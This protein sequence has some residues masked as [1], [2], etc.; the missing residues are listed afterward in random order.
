FDNMEKRPIKGTS[1]WVKYE[2]VLFVPVEATSISYGVLLAGTGQV[3]FKGVKFEIV[4]DTVPETG[5][6]KGRENKVLSFEVKAKAM[7]NEIKRITDEEKNTLKEEVSSID[8]EI[9]EGIISKEKAAELK[10]KKAQEHAANI[11]K[12]VAVE[13]EKLNQLVQDKV[14]GKIGEEAN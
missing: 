13:Q 4:D 2:I 10:L 6:N 11:E 5:I 9:E 14:D 12:R 3:W 8:K 7:G 1:D